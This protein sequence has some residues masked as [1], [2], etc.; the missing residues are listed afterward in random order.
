MVVRS[1]AE[2][3]GRREARARVEE[4]EEAV[5]LIRESVVGAVAE[6]MISG[7]NSERVKLCGLKGEE[8]KGQGYKD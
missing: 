4:E 3:T 1:P 5:V 8:E 7:L 2:E 6:A